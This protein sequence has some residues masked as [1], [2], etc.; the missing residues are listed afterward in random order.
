CAN[1]V[2]TR[3]SAVL[4]RVTKVRNYRS[5]T[6]GASAAA[7]VGK[8]EKIEEMLMHG[9]ARRLNQVH[10]AAAHT[11]LNFDV[12]FAVGKARERP[13]SGRQAHPLCNGRGKREVGGASKNDR[14]HHLPRDW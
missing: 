10:V 12:K 7:G 2:P 9:R 4:T 5:H 8:H 14:I 13:F 11:F 3:G 1:R 6:R